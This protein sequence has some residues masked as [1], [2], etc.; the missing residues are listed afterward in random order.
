[1]RLLTPL[2][3]A[4]HE[5]RIARVRA[6]AAANERKGVF[7]V[8]LRTDNGLGARLQSTL[9]ILAYCDEHGL[10]P[11]IRFSSLKDNSGIDYLPPLLSIRGSAPPQGG[12]F[13]VIQTV[14][15]LGFPVDYDKTLTLQRAHE[16]V[17]KYLVVHPS[18]ADELNG[19]WSRSFSS[20]RVLGVHYRGTDK[21]S[22]AAPVTFDKVIRNVEDQL[23]RDPSV[24]EVLVA[25]DDAKFVSALSTAGL[26]CPVRSRDDAYRSS[27][28]KPVH[29]GGAIDRSAVFRDA[30]VN[31]LL[32]SRCCFLVKTASFLSDWACVWR[33]ELPILLLNRPY[34][35]KLWFPARVL[36][37]RWVDAPVE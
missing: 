8:D 24:T 7:C 2:K 31:C 14:P 36:V 9:E 30:L 20:D 16:L 5:L 26:R 35:D 17:S 11:A 37:E 29:H 23:S 4:W 32:L 19:F 15:E 22:E 18:I 12:A 21:G 10:A 28:G 13:A 33:P 6:V 25:S 27:D 1:M 3:R 34:S